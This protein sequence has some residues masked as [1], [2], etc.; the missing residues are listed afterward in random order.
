MKKTVTTILMM[1]LATLSFTQKLKQQDVPAPVLSA[2]KKMYPAVNSIH[3]DKENK[4]YEAGFVLNKKAHTVVL[5][6]TGNMV[7]TEVEIERDQLPKDILAYV[8][9]Y[10]AGKSVKEIAKITDAK[11]NITYEVEIN[12]TDLLFDSNGIFL[13]KAKA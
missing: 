4:N 9:K 13:K 11:N 8:Q 5:D 10:Y 6:A 7:E 2:F 1:S 3:W 12:G